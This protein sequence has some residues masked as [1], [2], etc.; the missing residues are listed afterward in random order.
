[1][2]AIRTDCRQYRASQPCAPHKF[3]AARCD[4]CR[5]YDKIEERVLIVKLAA[6]GDVLRTTT[7]LPALKEKYPRSH[8]TWI[9][10]E[11]AFGL[12]S[13]NR[14][15]D[16]VLVVE[17]N[18]LEFLLTEEFDVV[19]GV[20]ADPFSASIT[21][22][23]RSATKFGFAADGRG[24]VIPL[25]AAAESWW[26][27]GLDDTLK[28]ANRA[29]YGEWLY[30][31]CEMRP[32]VR[33]PQFDVPID[34]RSRVD[35]YLHGSAPSA[36]H[37][38]LFNT[39]GS[40]R[41]RE[42]RWKPDHYSALARLVE[43]AHPGTATVLVGGPEEAELN[44]R[45]V[46]AHPTFIDGGTDNSLQTFGALVAACDW[47][48]TPDTLGYH[49]ACAAGTPAV[50][51]VG[52]TSPWELDLYESNV[53][54]Y[55]AMDCIGC[56]LSQC[57]FTSTCM[58]ALTPARVLNFIQRWRARAADAPAAT[59][60]NWEGFNVRSPVA[61]ALEPRAIRHI[62]ARPHVPVPSAPDHA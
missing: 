14:S 5:E 23:A 62:A 17:R 60:A 48:L 43:Q 34:A 27:L 61:P 45:L 20:D 19:I 3:T 16:R 41:W 6:M 35:E 9:T 37:F 4:D 13:G 18:Y 39:G 50:C 31:I 54:L 30:A 49:V 10:R 57:P 38:A 42:K 26:R 46:M 1:M 32:P 29:T 52:P 44:R 2:S 53:V 24:G 58:D 21:T 12:L 7:V 8:V 55:A 28:R 25:S 33:R 15:I 22:L 51:V 36:T 11:N 56:Y 40:D 59:A 47:M